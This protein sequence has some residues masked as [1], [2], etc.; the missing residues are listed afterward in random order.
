MM[1]QRRHVLAASAVA[2]LLALGGCAS[3]NQ[4]TSDVQSF[5]QWPTGRQPGRYFIER[6]P[7]QA[8]KAQR[9]P[10]VGPLEEGAHRAMQRAGFT[11]A[12]DAASADVIVQIGARIS[13]NDISPWSD[14]LWWRW[15]PN[16]WRSPS[17]PLYHRGWWA[18]VSLRNPPPSDREVAV[19]LRDRAT[20]VPLWEARALSTGFNTRPEALQAM[21]MAALSDFPK[22]IPESHSVSV[23]LAP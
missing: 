5:G 12:P 15:G 8:A 19:L 18:P 9:D 14:P 3:L 13:R 7:S 22:A 4:L 11:Q 16:H 17:W 20:S 23:P 1:N 10:M 2:A 21:L 6:L